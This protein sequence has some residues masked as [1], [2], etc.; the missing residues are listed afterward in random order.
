MRVKKI[1]RILAVLLKLYFCNKIYKDIGSVVSCGF[2][3]RG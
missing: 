2:L 3:S 1:L